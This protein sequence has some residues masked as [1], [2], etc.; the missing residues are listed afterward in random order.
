MADRNYDV[1]I[2]VGAIDKA[3]GVLAKIGI[4]SVALGNIISQAIM[5]AGR[6]MLEFGQQTLDSAAK[7]ERAE[8]MLAQAMKVRNIYSEQAVDDAMAYASSLQKVTT[9]GDED[10]ATTQRQLIAFGAK[11]QA[12]KDLTKATLDLSS[13]TGMDLRAAGDLVGKSIGSTT[14]ALMRYG[15]N[16][17]GAAS[18]TSR[19]ESAVKNI[20][21]LYGGSASA[22]A[23]TYD[24]QM[25]QLSN[26]IGDIQEGIGFY[27]I[28]AI[29]K[30]V[31][32]INTSILPAFEKA[33]EGT[34]D[35]KEG[36]NFLVKAITAISTTIQGV[37]F[38]FS[39]WGTVMATVA[40]IAYKA[41]SGDFK[42]AMEVGKIG[43]EELTTAI[44]EQASVIEQTNE[45]IVVSEKAKME[46]MEET[47]LPVIATIEE[48]WNSFYDSINEKG[49]DWQVKFTAMYNETL[50][51]M[52]K[53]FATFFV[54]VSKGFVNFKGL[55]TG[56]ANAMKMAMINMMAT[57]AAE[58]L[59][60]EVLMTAIHTAE[61]K[62]RIA[63]SSADAGAKAAAASAWM[64]FGALAIGASIMGLVAAFADKF[65]T[66]GIVGG[67]SKSG[68][69]VMARVNSGEM[70]LN[71][72]QQA[73][74]FG[75]A[76]GG[77][78]GGGTNV[79]ITGNYILDDSMA[80]TL[81][82]KV[83]DVIM[84]RVKNEI[85]I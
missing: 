21:A 50:G 44:T 53:S 28:P 18:S 49:W 52:K 19:M 31:T 10:I 4:N 3:S 35:M 71:A 40:A 83:S 37:V 77:G 27:L 7:Q 45:N 29:K 85:N 56:I 58:W 38:A 39:N 81:A 23:N 62:K 66:G 20:T 55:V 12:L 64:L 72:S 34:K 41:F 61:V 59:A 63:A 60:K 65:A 80:G 82:D 84:G 57:V 30:L 42:G 48:A 26:R 13:A 33:T 11:G 16:I 76:N 25:K 14:N 36:T 51:G 32:I 75:M 74:L 5:G 1:G 54:D 69:N 46:A 22:A 73:R 43:V 15:I 68:D 17:E 6:K 67:N 70:I 24:G 9:F 8:A 47:T 78:G 79:Y 2:M